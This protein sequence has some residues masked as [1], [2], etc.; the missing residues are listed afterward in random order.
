MR[1]YLYVAIATASALALAAP[2]AKAAGSHVLT[3]GK[4]GGPAVAPKAVLTAG[5][6]K[7]S[8]ATF[9]T[10]EVTVTCKKAAFSKRV[11]ANPP[12][13]GTAKLA[14]TKQTFGKCASNVSGVTVKS[15]KAMNL[16]Y[17]VA[18]SDATGDPVTVS[19][20]RT[21]KPLEFTATISAAGQV[22]SCSY[23]A[24]SI[25]GS[26]SNKDNVVSFSDQPFTFKTGG[27][28]CPTGTAD[29]TAAFGP[30]IDSSIKGSPKVFVN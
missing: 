17:N 20:R 1:R 26:F 8:T 29:F 18:V 15:V 30:I 23:S 11:I 10:T 25:T 4:L 7:G 9:T 14:A 16:P 12:A 19:G 2:A 6:A 21:S 22:F 27:S 3:T 28:L 24:A 13:P 5:L